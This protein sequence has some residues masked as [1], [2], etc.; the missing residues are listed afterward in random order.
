MSIIERRLLRS[1]WF[2]GFKLLVANGV[3]HDSYVVITAAVSTLLPSWVAI[4]VSG[5]RKAA[6]LP[7]PNTDFPAEQAMKDPK[8]YAM[9]CGQRAHANITENY[10]PVLVSLLLSGLV[11]PR[12][13]S[14][15]G[16][17]WIVARF[18]YFGGYVRD[19]IG[20]H[21]KGR[22]VGLWGFF[23]QLALQGMAFMTGATLLGL[24]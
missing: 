10:G 15:L 2:L 6:K 22:S 13:A 14:A 23:P 5:L 20:D 12:I 4:R 18:L 7:Y 21:G 24:W 17:A 3:V 11:Y 8:A 1:I 16:M 19:Q 9:N